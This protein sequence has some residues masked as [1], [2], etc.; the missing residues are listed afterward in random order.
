[1]SLKGVILCP[2]LLK[3]H[4]KNYTL[5]IAENKGLNNC[6]TNRKELDDLQNTN[7]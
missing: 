7:L 4:F 2:E 1:M 6:K 3:V 5:F